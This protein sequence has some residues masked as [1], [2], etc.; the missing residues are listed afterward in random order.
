MLSTRENDLLTQTGPGTPLGA[1]MREYWVPV[2]RSA[3]LVAGAA[4]I[5]IKILGENFVGFRS[6]EGIAGFM[7]EACPHRGASL[8]LAR[9]EKCGLRCI[10]HGWKFAPHGELLEAPT[11]PES[12]PLNRMKTGARPIMEQQG[13][14]WAWL[15]GA[16]PAAFR[17]LGF[18][19]LPDD[20]VLA[21]TAVVN[22][23]WLHPLETLWDVFHAQILHN[24]TNRSSVRAEAY[25]SANET[26]MAGDIRF[27]YPEM[28]VERTDYGFTHVNRDAA[29]ETHFHFIMPFIQHHTVTPGIRDDKALQISV[30]I[31]D[32]HTLLW[33]IFYNRY[34]P[35]KSDGF[36]LQG[37]GD[38]PDLSNFL[39]GF[40]VRSAENR[41]GQDR[42][43]MKRGESFSGLNGNTVLET[44]FLEDVACIES[45]GRLDRT[46]ELLAPVDKAI[47]EGRR[48]VLDAIEAH[49]SGKGPVG[50]DLDLSGV[51]ADFRIK[52][53]AA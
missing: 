22:C 36:A 28:T 13:I 1:L 23:S 26:R 9:N 40:P 29:K 16:Q 42:E 27:N 15:G 50:R 21:A 25:F 47:I 19:E 14:I 35:L 4:P 18:T 39:S 49:Q 37:F 11:H 52:S 41:W 12:A 33:M 10:Y 43:A 6:P 38:L 20:H 31:D 34:G 8:A 45:Q 17:S 24:Q 3:Q 5:R 2:A 46:K 7:N 53:H 48:T 51:E 30:P 32:D 44:I